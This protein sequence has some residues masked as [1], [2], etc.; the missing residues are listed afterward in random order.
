MDEF[1]V[2]GDRLRERFERVSRIGATGAGGVDR[3]TLTDANRKARDTLVGWLREAGLDMTVDE[4]GNVFGRRTSATSDRSC[5]GRTSTASPGAAGSTASS[6][7]WRSSS[8]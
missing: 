3:P 2:D 6:A 7:P 5:S 8:H 1:T 4:V